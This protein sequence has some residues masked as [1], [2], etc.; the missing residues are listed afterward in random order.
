MTD[1]SGWGSERSGKARFT[2]SHQMWTVPPQCGIIYSMEGNEYQLQGTG[3]CS[4]IAVT[5]GKSPHFP[6]F[7]SSPHLYFKEIT[8]VMLPNEAQ[9]VSKNLPHLL[10]KVSSASGYGLS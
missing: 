6:T 8:K 10:I 3:F 4:V 1:T 5:L 7:V 2:L 9:F